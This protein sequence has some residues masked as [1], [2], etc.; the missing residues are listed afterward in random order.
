MN[1]VKHTAIATL[2]SFVPAAL[3]CS[4]GEPA[5]QEEA[6]AAANAENG[7]ALVVAG[8][9]GETRRAFTSDEI[10]G[11]TENTATFN[12]DGVATTDFAKVLGAQRV[13][14]DAGG[15]KT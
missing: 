4:A 11:V 7:A 12:V 10:T 6:P 15:G 2:L 3:G 14:V 9:A 1:I 8:A 13:E 5:E